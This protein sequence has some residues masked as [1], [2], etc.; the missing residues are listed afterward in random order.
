M[1]RSGPFGLAC[2]GD[3]RI[4]NRDIRNALVSPLAGFKERAMQWSHWA[5]TA[6]IAAAIS[7]NASSKVQAGTD[8][9]RIVSLSPALTET[10]FALGLGANLVAV[11]DYCHEPP[12][13]EQLPRVGT[14]FTP[15][16]EDV[17]RAHPSIILAE[18]IDG[19][20]AMELGGFG[21]LTTYRWLTYDDIL[22]STRQLGSRFGRHREASRLIDEYT[23]AL[24]VDPAKSSIRVLLALAHVPG[25]LT[26]VWFI[27]RNSIHGRALEAAGANN[28]VSQDI[29]GPPRISLEETIG[30]Q[31]DAVVVLEQ[32][33][34]THS[35][36]LEDWRRLTGLRA[37]REGRLAIVAAPEA[38]AP[39]PRIRQL[40][41]KI[42]R[43]VTPWTTTFGRASNRTESSP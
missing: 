29:V 12:A 13:V 2:T 19:T 14:V 8:A 40:V 7:C 28:A 17:V 30:L 25:Q 22:E 27:R 11:S 1:S 10:V 3:S 33:E 43:T 26:E 15:R 38:Q 23:D 37:I 34:Q 35:E 20:K 32:S 4:G 6:W 31:P 18:R 36:L 24:R 42:R 9:A 5:L 16:Y 21:T 41:E 39:G